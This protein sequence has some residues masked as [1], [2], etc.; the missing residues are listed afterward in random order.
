M[1]P[2]KWINRN[3]RCIEIFILPSFQKGQ[4]LINRNMRCIEMHGTTQELPQ[5]FLINRNM[6]CIEMRYGVVRAVCKL[7]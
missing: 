2:R 6:R 7:D 4:T 5:F 1:A 3:M